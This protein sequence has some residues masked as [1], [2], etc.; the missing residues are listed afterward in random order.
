MASRRWIGGILAA[1]LAAALVWLLAFRREPARVA[2]PARAGAPSPASK[3][4]PVQER[5]PRPVVPATATHPGTPGAI[6]LDARWGNGAAELGHKLGEE[7]PEGPMSLAAGKKGDLWVLDQVNGRIQHFDAAGKLLGSIAVADTTQDLALGPHG[8]IYTLDRLGKS[9][10]VAYD[11]A[12]HATARDAVV[13]GSIDEGGAVTGLFVDE[14]GVYLER[15][16]NDAVRIAGGDGQFDA[17]RPIV[18]GRP[19]RDGSAFVRAA[20]GGRGSLTAS[21]TVFGRDGKQRWQKPISFPHAVLHLVL[22]DTDRRGHLFVGAEVADE[23]HEPPHGL[24]NLEIVVLRLGLAD[25][26]AMGALELA[27]STRPEEML[28]ELTVTDDGDVVQMLA[29]DDGVR[30]ASFRF[31]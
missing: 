16:H 20:I 25:G 6:H 28:R 2:P 30:I 15:E 31:P 18:A 5:A 24:M 7:A 19:S 10:V 29:L 17:E 27:A 21:V 9:E 22:I 3:A 8:E 4:A 13:G 14:D 12:G 23:S 26:A 11:A 1:A